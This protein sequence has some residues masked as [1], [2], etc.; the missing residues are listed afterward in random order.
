MTDE[1]MSLR[2]LLEKSPDADFLREMIGFAAERL[3]E[4]VGRGRR[5]SRLASPRPSKGDFETCS[6][7]PRVRT[8]GGPNRPQAL[9]RAR[10]DGRPGP[11]EPPSMSP[12]NNSRT[13][14]GEHA[15]SWGSSCCKALGSFYC[16]VG[17]LGRAA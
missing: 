10:R 6:Y 7:L 16:L 5:D 17:N 3:M 15:K 8:H 4:L 11:S 12:Q 13:R 14:R 9:V 1:M 2:A